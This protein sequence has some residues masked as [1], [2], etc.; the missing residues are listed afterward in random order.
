MKIRSRYS[1]V[2]VNVRVELKKN[3][4]FFFVYGE[5]C[6]LVKSHAEDIMNY[7]KGYGQTDSKCINY[8]HPALFAD[9]L[10]KKKLMETLNILC[11][12]MQIYFLNHF[13]FGSC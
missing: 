6:S 4:T 9:F 11:F 12:C 13:F 1:F 5:L 2:N 7:V 8:I 3:E 10:S